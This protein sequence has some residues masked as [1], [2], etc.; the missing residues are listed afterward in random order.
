MTVIGGRGGRPDDWD[1]QHARARARA[2]ERLDGP[3]D[4][5]EAAWLDEHL[6]S[7]AAIAADYAAQRLELR[8]LREPAPVP[9]RDLWARTAAAL[10]Q[11]S[12]HGARGRAR[13]SSLRPFALLAGALVVAIAV[14]TLT[15]SQWL[16]GNPTT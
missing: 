1:S 9:P 3:L 11:E 10:E 4:P 7:C 16:F 14:G 5:A 15:S 12:R 6:A 13:R 8:A 2:A